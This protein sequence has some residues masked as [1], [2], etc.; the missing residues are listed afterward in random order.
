MTQPYVSS[1]LDGNP[2]FHQLSPTT[3]GALP[4]ASTMRWS[5][6]QTRSLLG[7]AILGKHAPQSRDLRIDVAPSLP[8][9]PIQPPV[10]AKSARGA[11]PELHCQ[12]TFLLR[13]DG[14]P[15][16]LVTIKNK[17]GRS[18]SIR[19]HGFSVARATTS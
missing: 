2:G 7:A 1:A 15:G 11:A 8:S 19:L 10:C 9:R 16:I 12:Q 4:G 13:G 14:I 3:A 17:T 18:N 6:V 5:G